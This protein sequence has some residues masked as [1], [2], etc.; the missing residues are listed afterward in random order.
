MTTTKTSPLKILAISFATV[1]IGLFLFVAIIRLVSV[2]IA[3]IGCYSTIRYG[4]YEELREYANAHPEKKY[5]PSSSTPGVLFLSLESVSRQFISNY[6]EQT[7]CVAAGR[8]YQAMPLQQQFANPTL[9]YFGYALC[10]ED[11]LLAFL[12]QYPNFIDSGANFDGNLPAPAGR[13]SFGGDQFLRLTRD[14]EKEFGKRVWGIPVMFEIPDYR[15]GVAASRH[16]NG[17]G[18]SIQILGDMDS[19]EYGTGFPMTQAVIE[20]IGEIKMRY[21]KP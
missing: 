5:P 16:W 8:A 12:E 6:R 13:G 4:W 2:N 21:A 3:G 19:I 20:K 10:N 18:V 7:F 9:A 17:C 1:L 15:S 11:E 14:L